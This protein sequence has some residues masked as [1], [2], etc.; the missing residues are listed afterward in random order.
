MT[1]DEFMARISGVESGGNPDVVNKDSGAHGIFQIMPANWPSWSKEAGLGAN[2]PKT[3]EN[4]RKVARF[5]MQQYHDQFGSWEAVAV[6]WYAGPGAAAEYAKN[7]NQARFTV[8]QGEYPSI[9][10]YV[11]KIT[12]RFHTASTGGAVLADDLPSD[13]LPPDATPEQITKYIREHYPQAAP[14]LGNEEIRN[15]LVRPDIDDMDAIEIEA[16]LRK[17]NYWQ[18]HGPESR[19]FDALIAQDAQAAGALVDTAKNTLGDF[20]SRSGVTYTDEQLGEAAKKAIRAGWINLGGQVADPNVLN[21]FAVF[22]LGN[23]RNLD[24][25]LPSG[26]AA[27][28]ADTLGAIA[29]AYFVPMARQDLERWALDIQ[30]G[31]ATEEQF[32]GEMTW[33]AKDLFKDPNIHASIESGRTP[34]Q[35]FAPIR[36]VIA[37]T[38][39]LA[40]DQVDLMAPRFRDVLQVR[41]DKAGVTRPMTIGE[42]TK[43][44]R[45]QDAFRDTREYKATEA[46]I[47]MQLARSLGVVA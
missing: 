18:T 33:H 32:R 19:K 12:G 34:D 8:K 36:N 11:G 3:A 23:Q 39:E 14:F 35:I 31:K 46:Q 28:T 38:L 24:G 43:W 5:K 10:E 41:D 21:D 9:S 1:L 37:D 17:T 6:A 29:R 2:A 16:L 44:A 42:A 15:L 40:P 47:Q 4:Q 13:D 25:S 22:A 27:A 30:A 7:P 45:D 26:T 20:L